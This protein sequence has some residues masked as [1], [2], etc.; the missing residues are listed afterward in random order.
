MYAQ[1]EDVTEQFYNLSLAGV[2]LL[3]LSSLF[4]YL[5]G[6]EEMFNVMRFFVI[7]TNL[8]TFA[9]FIAL[10]YYRFKETGR[11]CSGDFIIKEPK[12][13]NDIY[14]LDQGRWILIYIVS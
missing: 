11:T 2:A 12:N 14:L 1:S 10:Q 9:W 8:A 6:K 4:Y 13:M 7:L 3:L 5:Q